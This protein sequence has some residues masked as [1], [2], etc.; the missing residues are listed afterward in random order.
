MVSLESTRARDAILGAA[1][2][3]AGRIDPLLARKLTAWVSEWDRCAAAAADTVSLPGSSQS[4]AAT[5]AAVASN[6]PA[7]ALSRS[8][9]SLAFASSLN[10]GQ[11][12]ACAGLLAFTSTPR[13]LVR[14]VA[15]SS[16]CLGVHAAASAIST[17]GTRGND[18]SD[19]GMIYTLSSLLDDISSSLLG[20]MTSNFL[21]TVEVGGGA[22]SGGGK[23]GGNGSITAP[24]CP[25]GTGGVPRCLPCGTGFWRNGSFATPDCSV[26]DDKPARAFYSNPESTTSDC[27]YG[28]PPGYLYPSC[29]TPL[30]EIAGVFGGALRAA[31]SGVLRSV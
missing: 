25:A 28:C 15:S 23:S 6:S 17:R 31:P 13:S 11:V 27:D 22:G 4:A 1:S 5:T 16:G 14:T 3:S 8:D 18:A 29:N 2:S 9:V 12:D 19:G 20:D 7:I 26:C 30:E 10:R 24:N 21:G